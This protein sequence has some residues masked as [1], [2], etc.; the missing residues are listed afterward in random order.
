V[1]WVNS[2]RGEEREYAHRRARELEIF[3]WVFSGAVAFAEVAHNVD[4][5]TDWLQLRIAPV[6]YRDRRLGHPRRG[7]KKIGVC[8]MRPRVGRINGKLIRARIRR[9]GLG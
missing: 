7:R 2:L 6:G 4:G 9:D 8:A 5:W 3:Q 1:D